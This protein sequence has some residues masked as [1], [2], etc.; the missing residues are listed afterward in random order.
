MLENHSNKQFIGFFV[1]LGIMAFICLMIIWPFWQ[2]L[3]L[4][5]ILAVLFY[6]FYQK[7]NRDIR[8]PNLAAFITILIVILIALLPMW[9]IGQLLFNEMVDVYNKFRLGELVLDKS[10]IIAH[11]PEQLKI[12]AQSLSN[13]ITVMIS[14]VTGS[15][16]ASV[17]SLLSNIASFFLSLFL[18]VFMLF[19]FLRDGAKIKAMAM[20]LSPLTEVYDKIL[21]ERLEAAVSGVV[22]G[23]FLVALIQG[24]VATIGFLIFGVPQPVL[25]GAFTVLA[26]LVPTVGTSLSII[27]AV[28][29]LFL[30]GHTGAGIGMA[31]WGAVAV[32]TIDN[33]VSPRIVGLRVKTPELLTLLAI[34]GGIHLFG[35]FG[36]LFGPILMSVFVTL[37]NIYREDLKQKTRT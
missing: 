7:I 18:L 32:G 10:Q 36:F 11:L 31:I 30:T 15:A 14:R 6:P 29:Y 21:I 19:Y 9:L 23:S 17:S 37:T 13:D 33:I 8:S 22:K 20:E 27:P 34:L 25:W 28:I 26:A 4:S 12:V 3:A 35:F 1:L 2:M 5:G 24:T 16:F